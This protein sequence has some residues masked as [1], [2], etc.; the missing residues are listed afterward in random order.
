M[1]IRYISKANQS[2]A[3][4]GLNALDNNTHK[5]IYSSIEDNQLDGQFVDIIQFRLW[6]DTYEIDILTE[7]QAFLEMI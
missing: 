6:W 4:W 7:E 1:F 2:V 5:C 3:I